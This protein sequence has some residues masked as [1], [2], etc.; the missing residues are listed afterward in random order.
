M[1]SA[2]TEG[3]TVKVESFYYP[4][5]SQPESSRYIF[6]YRITIINNSA[7]TVQLLKRH[8]HIID[9]NG[10]KREVEGD[11][12]IGKQPVLK[13][14][15]QHQYMSACNLETEIGQMFGTYLMQSKSDGRFF[16]VTIPSFDMIVPAKLN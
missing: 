5:G 14:G 2:T 4:R 10:S 7:Y 13:P 15:Q 8:W 3:I 16:D 1:V 6:A 12:V 11:G 9:S